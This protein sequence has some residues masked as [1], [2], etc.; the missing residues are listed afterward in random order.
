M[1]DL[2]YARMMLR[3][4]G[5]DSRALESMLDENLFDQEIFGFHAEQAVEKGVKSWLNLVDIEYPKIHDLEKL[6]ALLKEARQNVPDEFRKLMDLSDFAV[7][8]R[9]EAF[10]VS[11]LPFSRKNVLRDVKAFLAYVEILLQSAENK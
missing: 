9:Y 5:K 6:F 1:P 11:D 4:A 2:E 7:Q 10:E 8:F 3:M